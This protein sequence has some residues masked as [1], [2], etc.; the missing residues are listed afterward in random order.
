MVFGTAILVGQVFSAL[1]A[2]ALMAWILYARCCLPL[3]SCPLFSNVLSSA[4]VRGFRC[5]ASQSILRHNRPAESHQVRHAG[6]RRPGDAYAKKDHLLVRAARQFPLA[7]RP[8]IFVHLL[9]ESPGKV[10][11]KTEIACLRLH[12]QGPELTKTSLRLVSLVYYPQSPTLVRCMVLEVQTTVRAA[13][14]VGSS[15]HSP[16]LASRT[17]VTVPYHHQRAGSD[18][19]QVE[20]DSWY[21]RIE[22]DLECCG[23]MRLSSG[24]SPGNAFWSRAHPGSAGD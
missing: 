24:S 22:N 9:L 15:H 4:G 19:A 18:R 16:Q 7:S 3:P 8:Q 6:L 17:Y 2:V 14:E 21:P 1:I 13:S 23:S 12:Q 5:R 11:C 10:P 20:E